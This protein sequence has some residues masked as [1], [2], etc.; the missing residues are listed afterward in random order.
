MAHQPRAESIIDKA[1]KNRAT[2]IFIRRFPQI[3]DIFAETGTKGVDE[4]DH[5]PIDDIL[6]SL[7]VSPGDEKTK[8]PFIEQVEIE[9][10]IIS[11]LGKRTLSGSAASA[12]AANLHK[13]SSLK[14]HWQPRTVEAWLKTQA[15]DF[16]S[17]EQIKVLQK[18][19]RYQT[20]WIETD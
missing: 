5:M 16:L 18:S 10:S 20:G 1:Y 15:N 4:T 6:R 8:N 3:I 17:Q 11:S 14:R 13:L 12:K 2:T 7:I 19:I 9:K